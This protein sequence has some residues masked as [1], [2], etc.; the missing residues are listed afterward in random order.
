[1]TP[2]VVAVTEAEGEKAD[3]GQD[4]ARMQRVDIAILCCGIFILLILV[5]AFLTTL[6]S[7]CVFLREKI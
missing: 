2:L 3:I 5:F 6:S 7:N 1:M 4:H